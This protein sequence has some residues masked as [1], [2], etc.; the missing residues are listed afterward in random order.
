M[1]R[2]DTSLRPAGVYVATADS[3][4][5]AY[6]DA[7]GGADLGKRVLDTIKGYRAGSWTGRLK[8]GGKA[9]ED[10]QSGLRTI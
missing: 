10:N 7:I 9:T 6:G 5:T 1:W 2:T 3:G 8:W 4:G